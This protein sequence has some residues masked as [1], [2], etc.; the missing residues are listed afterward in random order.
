MYFVWYDDSPTKTVAVKIGE[1]VTRYIER[2]GGA[3]NVCMLNDTVPAS[4][5]QASGLRADLR[6]MPARNV[7]K[8]YFWV[9]RD[10]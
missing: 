9:G 7:P 4:E 2:Y 10:V 5:Y 1:A 8:N 6:V 3:P